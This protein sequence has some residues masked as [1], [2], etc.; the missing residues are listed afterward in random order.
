MELVDY[1]LLAVVAVVLGLAGW[2]IYKAK[3]NGKKCIGCPDSCACSAGNCSGGCSGCC[4]K[5]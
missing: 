5:Q 3:K 2:Y 1:I 4:D